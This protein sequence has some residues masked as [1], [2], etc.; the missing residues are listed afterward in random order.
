MYERINR[1]A[2]NMVQQL[3]DLFKTLNAP[4]TLANFGSLFKVQ[5]HQESPFS[6]LLFARL[7]NKG[8]FIW[9]HR[10][11]LLTIQHTQEHID[12]FVQAFRES[13]IELQRQGFLSGDGHL[14]SGNE[15]VNSQSPTNPNARLGKDRQGKPAWFIP[16]SMNP[17]RFLEVGAQV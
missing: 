13:I 1:L 8:Y 4:M 12:G 11:C 17:G 7:R 6:E 3:N 2:N 5:F 14:Q 10:P 16:D 15:S 9:D